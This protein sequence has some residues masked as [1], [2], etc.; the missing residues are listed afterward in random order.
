MDL[1]M[2]RARAEQME[3][4]GRSRAEAIARQEQLPGLEHSRVGEGLEQNRA[5]E[6]AGREQ[7][8]SCSRVEA[9]VG[10]REE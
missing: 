2:S 9:G 4:L 3:E 6:K 7:R 5:G 8:M 10:I 1:G